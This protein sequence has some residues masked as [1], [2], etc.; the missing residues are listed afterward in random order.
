MFETES[1]TGSNRVKPG[2]SGL[3]R[4]TWCQKTDG[5]GEANAFVAGDVAAAGDGRTP[6]RVKPRQTS[7]GQNSAVKCQRSG[8]SGGFGCV[9]SK[10]HAA[11]GPAAG[12]S[13]R[14]LGGNVSQTVSNHV[15][16]QQGCMKTK[17]SRMRMRKTKIHVRNRES[18]PVKPGQSPF[19]L[20]AEAKIERRCEFIQVGRVYR[21]MDARK[22]FIPGFNQAWC[23]GAF[24]FHPVPLA[25]CYVQSR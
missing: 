22:S 2:Q 21:R 5:F 3:W 7:L 1:Q 20:A 11:A 19:G 12:H 23:L 8:R 25:C 4:G 6:G 14:P 18:N 24:P 13:R 9:G 16:A 15:K 17:K 10:P